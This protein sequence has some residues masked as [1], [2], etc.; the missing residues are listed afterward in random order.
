MDTGS[1]NQWVD[2]VAYWDGVQ[3]DEAAYPILL[4]GALRGAALLRARTGTPSGG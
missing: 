1:Q 3:L 4:A 2:G